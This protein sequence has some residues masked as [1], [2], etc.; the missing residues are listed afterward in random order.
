MID[1]IIFKNH[2]EGLRYIFNPDHKHHQATDNVKNCHNRHQ[3]FGYM[4]D[5]FDTAYHDEC[6]HGSNNNT[7]NPR[8]DTKRLFA[9]GADG[10]RL[11]HRAEEAEREHRHN[12]KNTG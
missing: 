7:D 8:G 6:R 11:H 3:L 10:I 12:G 5:S 9:G 2:A 1:D 4:R